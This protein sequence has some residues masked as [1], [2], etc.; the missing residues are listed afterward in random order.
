MSWF[1][2]DDRINWLDYQDPEMRTKALELVATNAPH[3]LGV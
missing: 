3:L 1:R 2:R